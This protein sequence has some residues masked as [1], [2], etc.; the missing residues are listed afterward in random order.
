MTCVITVSHD[1]QHEGGEAAVERLGAPRRAVGNPQTDALQQDEVQTEYFEFV[2]RRNA[3]VFFGVSPSCTAFCVRR[4]R[5]ADFPLRQF[6]QFKQF[7][8]FFRF[9]PDSKTACTELRLLFV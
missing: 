2:W 3:F 8:H 5:L 6:K 4:C 1:G 9:H 7:K